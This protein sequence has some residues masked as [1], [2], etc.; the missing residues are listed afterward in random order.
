M[1]ENEIGR[2]PIVTKS[3]KLVGM[4]TKR[5]MLELAARKSALLDEEE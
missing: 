1:R 4:V 3:G 2:L 5:E